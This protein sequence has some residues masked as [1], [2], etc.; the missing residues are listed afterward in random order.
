MA[1][2][3]VGSIDPTCL[4]TFSSVVSFYLSSIFSLLIGTFCGPVS[5]RSIFIP[6]LILDLNCDKT[7]LHVYFPSLSYPIGVKLGEWLDSNAKNVIF[8]LVTFVAFVFLSLWNTQKKAQ[9]ISTTRVHHSVLYCC[10]V[11]IH[12]GDIKFNK[13]NL[14]LR[15]LVFFFSSYSSWVLLGLLY[16]LF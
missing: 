16:A 2:K 15:W 3:N 1:R 5:P 13:L 6:T 7:R 12:A 9:S 8:S 4:K 11:E 10:N 14:N